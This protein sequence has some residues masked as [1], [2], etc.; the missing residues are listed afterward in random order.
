[1][2]RHTS[3]NTFEAHVGFN[4]VSKMPAMMP[5]KE[6][7]EIERGLSIQGVSARK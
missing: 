3:D 5:I 4:A 2:D 6:T 1:M 7:L